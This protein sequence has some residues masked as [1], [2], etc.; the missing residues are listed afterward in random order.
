MH[1][2][3]RIGSIERGKQADLVLLRGDVA[4]DIG[5]V[6]HPVLVVRAGVA[7]DPQKL[8]DATTGSVGRE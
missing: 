7:Y 6:A 1:R 4:A 2:F 3:D 5:S 8:I